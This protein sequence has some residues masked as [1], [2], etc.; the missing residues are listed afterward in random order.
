MVDEGQLGACQTMIKWNDTPGDSL[1]FVGL[2]FIRTTPPTL[3]CVLFN[4]ADSATKVIRE[5]RLGSNNY[6]EVLVW[7]DCTGR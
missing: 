6:S 3:H 2:Y 4:H 1:A 5:S 7:C